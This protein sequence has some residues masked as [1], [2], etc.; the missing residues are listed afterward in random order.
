MKITNPKLIFI[1]IKKDNIFKRKSY[2]A[3]MISEEEETL[4]YEESKDD[5]VDEEGK[6][7]FSE[8]EDEDQGELEHQ[9][10]SNRSEKDPDIGTWL[11]HQPFLSYGVSSD[12]DGDWVDPSN[13]TRVH[14]AC[15][16]SSCA[17]VPRISQS[18]TS[19]PACR[20]WRGELRSC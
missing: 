16:R 12:V 6:E 13:S 10:G 7:D 1:F 15:S 19:P 5:D 14:H 8:E 18:A 17:W 11:D 20:R 9:E 2:T 4:D 3:A